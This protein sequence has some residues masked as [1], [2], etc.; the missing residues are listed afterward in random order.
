MRGLLLF[1]AAF[2][3]YH[4]FLNPTAMNR[5]L[6][7]AP[8]VNS[9]VE[10]MEL[11]EGL[12][13]KQCALIIQ[14][15][16][17]TK[18]YVKTLDES[19]GQPI[20]QHQRIVPKIR[21]ILET[22]NIKVTDELSA[23]ATV[24][25]VLCKEKPAGNVGQKFAVDVFSV[26][27]GKTTKMPFVVGTTADRPAIPDP[28]RIIPTEKASPS[29][30]NPV[31]VPVSG[32]NGE[33][34]AIVSPEPQKVFD[35]KAIDTEKSKENI[36]KAYSAREYVIPA[37]GTK[38]KFG[39]N[40]CLEAWVAVAP[41]SQIKNK[42]QINIEDFKERELERTGPKNG[43]LILNPKERYIVAVKNNGTEHIG[44]YLEIDGIPFD[45]FKKGD[46]AKDA[47][48]A[49]LVKPNETAYFNGWLIDSKNIS[50]FDVQEYPPDCDG[51]SQKN[52]SIQLGSAVAKKI[53]KEADEYIKKT[54][55]IGHQSIQ[56][57][58]PG[59]NGTLQSQET[60]ESDYV[61]FERTC[62][63]TINYQQK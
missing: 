10:T 5:I 23:D 34:G 8:T 1:S 35:G 14:K 63:L 54:K 44:I 60:V 4:G 17:N 39:P 19:T 6:A 12:V 47:P 15:K 2:G 21:E 37:P 41:L 62:T 40:K 25:I 3:L 53:G 38:L 9:P 20:A 56:T 49:Y 50:A 51:E 33:K 16:P 46:L 22:K 59:D 55:G 31:I 52:G 13:N 28:N 57:K 43:S 42:N 11:I 36:L 24:V 30:K 58:K 45:K 48:L 26:D 27:K 61:L 18:V 32:P 29:L 7:S